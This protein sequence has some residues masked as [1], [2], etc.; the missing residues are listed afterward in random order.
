MYIMSNLIADYWPLLAT[1][2]ALA[3]LAFPRL[4][5]HNPRPKKEPGRNIQEPASR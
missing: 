5:R 1:L 2:A 4:S 3:L